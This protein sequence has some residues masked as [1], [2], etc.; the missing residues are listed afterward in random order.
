MNVAVVRNRS[1]EGVVARCGRP[2]PETYGRKSVQRVLDALRAGGHD[3]ACVEADVTMFAALERLLG[4]GPRT[5]G[6]T[7]L[8]LNMGYGIQGDC[9]YTHAPAM[10][11]MAG[12]PYTGATPLG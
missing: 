3:V 10:L 11:E 9:R 1:R 6:P 8:A 12:I 4:R 7:G 5:G 2:S